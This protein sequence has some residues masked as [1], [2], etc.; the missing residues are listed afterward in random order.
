VNTDTSATNIE[1]ADVLT[2]PVIALVKTVFPHARVILVLART[3][4]QAEED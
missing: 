2:H 1:E 4:S 3:E